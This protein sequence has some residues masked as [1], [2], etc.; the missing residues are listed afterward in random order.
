MGE[1]E[2]HYLAHDEAIR[3]NKKDIDELYKMLNGLPYDVKNMKD[4][5]VEIKESIG[6]MQD[7]FITKEILELEIRDVENRLKLWIYGC[8]ISVA[9]NI[10]L[11]LFKLMH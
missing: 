1:C 7:K 2:A 10:G 9:L 6:I 11:F 4:M 3:E 5:L 8:A